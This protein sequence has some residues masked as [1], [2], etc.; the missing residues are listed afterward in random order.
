MQK[1]S[2]DRWALIKI[3]NTWGGTFLVT[4]YK[5]PKF[6]VFA[7]WSCVCLKH[8]LKQIAGIIA[9]AMRSREKWSYN[10]MVKPPPQLLVLLQ[11][12]LCSRLSGGW[13]CCLRINIGLCSPL[14]STVS[15]DCDYWTVPYLCFSILE[16]L[17]ATERSWT[18]LCLHRH[19][20]LANG[21]YLCQ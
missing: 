6:S 7:V 11:L 10:Y 18:C 2:S 4:S 9:L 1:N 12:L 5:E 16:F 20:L 19:V 13:W 15:S 17:I 8:I 14:P 21:Y 3:L